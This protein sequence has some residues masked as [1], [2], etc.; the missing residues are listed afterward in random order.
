MLRNQVLKDI[1]PSTKVDDRAQLEYEVK[2]SIKFDFTIYR[3]R[4]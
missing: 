1:I 2:T 4:I 3:D